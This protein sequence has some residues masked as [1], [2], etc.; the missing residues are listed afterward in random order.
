MLFWM[1]HKDDIECMHCDRSRHV[2]VVNEDGAF[3]TT[4]VVVKQLHY[5]HVTPTVKRL[6]LSKETVK[7]MRWHKGSMIAK[8]SILCRILPMVRPGGPWTALIQNLQGTSGVSV[9]ACRW[10]VS[11]LTAPIVVRI[12]AG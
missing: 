1:E 4:K 11:N 3:V 2:K 10:I 12:L 6:H 5:M 9:L 8:I 7:Q